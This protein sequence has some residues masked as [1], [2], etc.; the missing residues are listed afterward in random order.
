MGTVESR[1]LVASS[2]LYPFLNPNAVATPVTT[3]VAAA[4]AA[5]FQ[6]KLA[7]AGKTAN[8]GLPLRSNR[9]ELTQSLIRFSLNYICS[10]AE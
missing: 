4:A 6:S 2:F 9:S 3:K 10:R 1:F 5:T 8:I 7:T